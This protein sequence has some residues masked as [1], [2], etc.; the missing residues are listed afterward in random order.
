MDELLWRQ[1]LGQLH[2]NRLALFLGSDLPQ[3]ITGLPSRADLARG[4]AR[5]HGLV[6]TTSLAAA[7]EQAGVGSYFSLVDYLCRELDTF[8]K[9]PQAIHQLIVRIPFCVIVTTAYDDLL[10]RAF[11]EAHKPV[12]RLVQPD[13]IPFVDTRQP[14]IIKLY[15]DL[16]QRKTLVITQSDHTN[17]WLD[18]AHQ[19]ILQAVRSVLA[20]SAA[21][22]VG[23][24]LA[25]PDFL[26]LWQSILLQTGAFAIGAYAIVPDLPA[27]D[28]RVWQD[29]HIRFLDAQPFDVLERL[30]AA[31]SQA[32]PPDGNPVSPLPPPPP[33]ACNP[34]SDEVDE[35]RVLLRAHRHTLGVY[36]RRAAMVG[37]A[38]IPPEVANGI[39]EA[40]DEIQRIKEVLRAW[41]ASVDEHP[42]DRAL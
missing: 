17:L 39:R 10:E 36:L 22:F 37:S 30:A 26:L 28:R 42:D 38:N 25:D 1:L 20:S 34:S 8:D 13:D 11:Q 32:S 41:G 12:A 4:L 24:D 14:A 33:P 9:R 7:A 40:R 19:P 27:N 23:H 29:R 16:R 2:R 6:E 31:L 15:G 35:Q 18:P 5:E 21:L 3:A